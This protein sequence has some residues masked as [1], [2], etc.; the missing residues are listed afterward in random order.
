MKIG[1]S[2]TM[3][4]VLLTGLGITPPPQSHATAVEQKDQGAKHNSEQAAESDSRL[5]PLAIVID[6]FGNNMNG[7]EDMMNMPVPIT[8]AVMPFL[9][10][11]K[12]DAE[13]AFSKGH[14]VFVHMPM[15]P[16][17]GKRSWLG[18]GAITSDLSDDEIRKRVNEAIDQVPH[19]VGMNNHMGSKI[20]K[21]PRIMKAVLSVCK[22]RGLMFLDSKTSYRS[23]VSTIAHELGVPVIENTLFFDDVYTTEHISKQMRLLRSSLGKH[24]YFVAIGHVGPPGKK[25]AS[26]IRDAIPEL[27]KEAKLVKASQL[28]SLLQH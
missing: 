9:P 24:P 7:T 23:I 4:M 6:D 3:I 12:K 16:L 8:V 27:Q 28:P 14:D 20:T 1:Y 11:T 10:S 19:A 18:P 26:I 22:E 2:L 15:E 25:T 13:L 17:R 21:D 5:K